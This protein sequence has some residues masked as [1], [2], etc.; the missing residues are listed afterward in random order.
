MKVIPSLPLLFLVAF[1]CVFAA[2]CADDDANQSHSAR[3]G[4]TP[5]GDLG[6]EDRFCGPNQYCSDQLIAQCS[7]GCLSDSNCE[8]DQVCFKLPNDQLGSC[9][10]KAAVDAWLNGEEP[11]TQSPS[12][13]PDDGPSDG[14][15]TSTTLECCINGAF[16]ACPDTATLEQCGG[17][18]FD[19]IACLDACS[20]DD[21]ACED[22]CFMADLNS[23]VDPDPSACTRDE[24]RD[25]SCVRDEPDTPDTPNT[26]SCEGTWDGTM[27]DYD[28]DC[29]S[30]NCVNNKCYAVSNGNPCDY[31]SDCASDNCTDGCCYSNA[32]GSP[33]DY[34][35][36][37]NSDNCY[38]GTCQ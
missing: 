15:S 24:S 23:H 25:F 32:A 4:I 14:P 18:T 30:D 6:G 3:S 33:C 17:I 16:Y 29:A 20:L 38:N 19:L 11:D 9:Q 2:G 1:A 31:D 12:D 21:W 37:C 8:G 27:C 26:N 7:V 10:S 36:D 22:A 34:D 13:T 5:C 35:S 28:S